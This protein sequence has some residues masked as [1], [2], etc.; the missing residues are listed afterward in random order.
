LLDNW[1]RP[2]RGPESVLKVDRDS[3]YFSDM[4]PWRNASA[5]RKTAA[6]LTRSDCQRIGLDITDFQLEYPLQ[7]LLLEQ[8]RRITFI[9]VGVDNP[10]RR[11]APP[12]PGTP[13]AMVCLECASDLS[14]IGRYR[15]FAHSQVIEN[16]VLF[17]DP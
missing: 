13:C 4:T 7:A 11:F 14:R 3:Q 12:V 8:N 1:V 5:F 10:S 16:F 9:H 17:S 6:A 2:L 15:Q